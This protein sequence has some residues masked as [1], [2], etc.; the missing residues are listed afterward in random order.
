MVSKL[1]ESERNLTQIRIHLDQQ[2]QSI[3]IS[4]LSY[5]S[6]L[7]QMSQTLVS[8]RKIYGETVLELQNVFSH[9][10]TQK[11][12]QNF[13]PQSKENSLID[14]VDI[15]AVESLKTQ[16]NQELQSAEVCLK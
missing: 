4:Q 6:K 1:T 11:I 16:A 3:H 7:Q 9:L 2:R 5:K 12:H 10:K 15:D 8:F 13:T 14:Y